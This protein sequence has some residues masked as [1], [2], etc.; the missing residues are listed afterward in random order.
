[1]KPRMADLCCLA[2]GAT[3]GYQLAGFHVTG[4]DLVAS[5]NYCGDDF[6]QT[7]ALTF[8][9][10]G[11][12][13]VHA[14]PP[15]Q[16]YANVTR[17]TGRQDDHPALI[18]PMR[19]KLTASGLPWVMENVRTL[20]LRDP[21]MLCGSQFGLPIRRHR[22]FEASFPLFEFM[23]P[24]RHRSSDLA[25]EHKAETGLRRRDGLR[26]DDRPRGSGG[27]PAGLHTPSRRTAD[28]R[29]RRPRRMTPWVRSAVDLVLERRK[30]A[31]RVDVV[32]TVFGP[33]AGKPGDR[34]CRLDAGRRGTGVEL[35]VTRAR[36]SVHRLRPRQLH[37]LR[38]GR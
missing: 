5:P 13:A 24:C 6:V 10:S 23:E 16:H 27:H 36:A 14:S 7:D 28:G 26:V 1:V 11:F 25:F 37:L 15:C 33:D 32:D 17:W 21:V 29:T 18:A 2:G 35:H 38:R 19:E 4:V 30:L 34:R 12:D 22:Y 9:L 20:E 8:D 31:R 3:K